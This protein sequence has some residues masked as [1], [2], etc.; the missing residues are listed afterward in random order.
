ML[1]CFRNSLIGLFLIFHTLCGAVDSFSWVG[2]ELD[3]SATA[4]NDT[5]ETVGGDGG[6]W[7]LS[8]RIV[9]Q[10]PLSPFDLE[11]HWLA[12]EK[13]AFGE[14]LFIDT[15]GKSPFRTLDMEKVH[16][17]DDQRVIIS[18]VDR[19]TASWVSS[20]L[21]I[22]VGRQ[23]V[24]WGEAYYF[25]IN[26]L[27]G[28]FPITETNR[29]YKQGIDGLTVTAS[30]GQF[31]DLALVAAPSADTADNI[32]GNLVMP[33]GTGS[34]TL[35]V[36]RILDSRKVGVGYTVDVSGAKLYG[37]HLATE[38]DGGNRFRETVAGIESQAGP[39]T[40]VLG[41]LYYNGWGTTDVSGYSA[42][43]LPE[44]YL[45]GQALT[46]GRYSGAIQVTRQLT[47]LFTITPGLFAN[48]SDGSA[49]MRL[50]GGWSFS[51]LTALTGGVF[52]GLGKRPEAGVWK[53]EYGGAPLTIYFE[54][55][56]SI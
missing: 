38:E 26:D 16:S 31:S 32:A 6:Q 36:G 5:W 42:F 35:T 21:G 11:L 53:S 39:Y 8:G 12:T 54:L 46:L 27:F 49:L 52:V 45:S 25:N 1:P 29:L 55:V 9:I 7:G 28:A 10:E 30:L 40:H 43:N 18:E 50:D 17:R 48:L 51:D 3:G 24:T 2:L 23:A 41:E 44:R 56:H 14:T 15:D 20:D 22:T 37:T 34:L 33:L 4:L 13:R 47:P 19:L